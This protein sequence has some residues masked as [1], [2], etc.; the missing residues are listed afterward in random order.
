MNVWTRGIGQ[1]LDRADKPAIRALESSWA[2]FPSILYGGLDNYVALSLKRRS[3]AA[4]RLVEF[5]G[6]SPES[7]GKDSGVH[8]ALCPGVA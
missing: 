3:H 7:R 8:L 5:C 6:K 1:G 4:A 2:T